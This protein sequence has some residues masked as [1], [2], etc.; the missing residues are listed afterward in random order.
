MVVAQEVAEVYWLD[1]I[2]EYQ[3]W[4]QLCICHRTRVKR[5]LLPFKKNLMIVVVVVGSLLW[6]LLMLLLNWN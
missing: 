3:R 1:R 5:D 6:L 2:L 4:V